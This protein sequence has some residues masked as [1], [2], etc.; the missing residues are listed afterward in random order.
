MYIGESDEGPGEGGRCGIHMQERGF[1]TPIS[2]LGASLLLIHNQDPFFDIQNQ[3]SSMPAVEFFVHSHGIK[4]G[5]TDMELLV[6]PQMEQNTD[7][8]VPRGE[9]LTAP[10][11]INIAKRGIKSARRPVSKAKFLP[12]VFAL[13]RYHSI[14]IMITFVPCSGNSLLQIL[15][16]V[17]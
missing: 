11:K 10:R 3:R 12:S 15:R 16:F 7:E 4:E 2:P 17:R 9:P 1:K 13:Y 14:F 8:Q 5:R 6:V